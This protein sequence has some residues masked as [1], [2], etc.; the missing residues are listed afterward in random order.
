MTW[1][2]DGT[3]RVEA[4]GTFPTHSSTCTRLWTGIARPLYSLYRVILDIF[5]KFSAPTHAVDAPHYS[6]AITA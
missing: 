6:D 2:G 5:Y 3:L 1:P 4:T